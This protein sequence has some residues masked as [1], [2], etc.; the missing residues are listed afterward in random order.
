MQQ[1]KGPRDTWGGGSLKRIQN[2]KNPK[3]KEKDQ[4]QGRRGRSASAV[5]D[6]YMYKHVYIYI[7][8]DILS[9]DRVGLCSPPGPPNGAKFIDIPM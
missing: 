9:H 6:I 1:E 5:A 4:D 7:Y 8:M 2:P 3:E